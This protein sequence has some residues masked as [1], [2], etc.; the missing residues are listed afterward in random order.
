MRNQG[1]TKHYY[2][3]VVYYRVDPGQ[4]VWQANA[5]SPGAATITP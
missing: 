2:K 1:V 4:W 3:A 5:T